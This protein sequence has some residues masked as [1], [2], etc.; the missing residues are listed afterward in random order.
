MTEQDYFNIVLLGAPGSGK[1]TQAHLLKKRYH[2]EHVST[3]ELYRKEI[4]TGSPIGMMAKR[5]IDKGNL[6][7][8]ELTLDMLY[9]FCS[10]FKNAHGFLLD[11][12][13]RTLDQAQM[14]EG[15]GYPHVIPVTLAVYIKVNENEAVERLAKRAILLKRTDD[16]PEIIRKRFVNY[17][18]QTKPLI[19]H[20]RAQNKLLKVDGM[21]GVEEVF[22]NICEI[23]DVY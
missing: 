4:A 7:P 21:Q 9:H 8:N 10:S 16:T 3:G 11:G 22:L 15:I 20:Y 13:P 12:V 14:M 17:E 18:N 1:G 6:C 23:L 2:L 19:A 5:I